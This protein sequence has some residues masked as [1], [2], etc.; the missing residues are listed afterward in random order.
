MN[1]LLPRSFRSNNSLNTISPSDKGFTLIELMVAITIIAILA[2]ISMTLFTDVQRNGRDS[3]RKGDVDAISKALEA[4]YNAQTG[5][6]PAALAGTMFAGDVVPTDPR[7]GT[8]YFTSG[9]GTAQYIVCATLEKNTGNF[10]DNG[11]TPVAA[12]TGSTYC[13][14]GAQ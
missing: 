2:T 8:G 3:R 5:V 11:T 7:T 10:S 14:K 4:A 9:L 13:K 12:N 1:K 6:Y